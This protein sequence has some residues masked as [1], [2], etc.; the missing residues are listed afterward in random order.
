MY[1]RGEGE[2]SLGPLVAPVDAPYVKTHIGLQ[3]AP[4]MLQ[5]LIAH[6]LPAEIVRVLQLSG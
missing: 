1:K 3:R 4:I 5:L 2:P 6:T